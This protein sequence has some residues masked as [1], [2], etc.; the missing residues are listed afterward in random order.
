MGHVLGIAASN[1]GHILQCIEVFT[2]GIWHAAWVGQIV[3]I[4]LFDVGGVTAKEI[5]VALV[6][7]V[8]SGLIAHASLTSAFLKKAFV[9]WRTSRDTAVPIGGCDCGC[10]RACCS[11]GHFATESRCL[12]QRSSIRPQTSRFAQGT[13]P[14][15]EN[16]QHADRRCGRASLR[17]DGFAH[18]VL[19]YHRCHFALGACLC[20]L[21]TPPTALFFCY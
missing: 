5:R 16:T 10:G 14:V 3:F 20:A 1:G 13:F 15:L 17:P 2:P 8:N 6:G 18:S 12:R 21:L 4:H 11:A 19:A 9:G 7:L